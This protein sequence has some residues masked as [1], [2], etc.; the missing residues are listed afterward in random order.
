MG[1]SERAI[2]LSDSDLDTI[3]AFMKE[4]SGVTLT[5]KKRDMVYARLLK[6]LR[7]LN[8]ES[9]AEYC[10]LIQSD[11]GAT[12]RE[13]TIN[14]LTTNLTSL[15]REAHHFEHLRDH[16]LRPVVDQN[17]GRRLRIWSS[18][19]STGEEPYSIA[20]TLLS[21]LSDVRSLDAKILATDIDTKVLA[22]ARSG[23]Y[24]VGAVGKI[25]DWVDWRA[26]ST[27]V[28]GEIFQF[29]P[30]V[31]SLI[32]FKQLNLMSAWPMR[33]P[34]DV[35]FCRNVLI[36]FDK[37]TQKMLVERFSRLLRP[38]GFLY[39]GHSENLTGM[40]PALELKGKSIYQKLSNQT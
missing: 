28:S 38:G 25:S 15:F 37:G 13:F 19:C 32:T 36:Y 17:A 39:I 6:R 35:I 24:Q 14:A 31:R 22:I 20:L 3:I 18:A 34:F 5:D 23:Q 40:S 10:T 27:P 12:E 8:L 33:G 30:T 11:E 16:V 7:A 26:F 4:Q 1:S 21:Q 29:R 2:Q 9:F